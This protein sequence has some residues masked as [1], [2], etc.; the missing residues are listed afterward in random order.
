M[1]RVIKFL[2]AA[3]VALMGT[4]PAR[5]GGYFKT[6]NDLYSSCST[7]KGERFYEFEETLCL[8][9]V[10]AVFDSFSISFGTG[11]MAR[12]FCSPPNSTVVQL[13]DIAVRFLEVNPQWRD[14]PAAT[15]VMA[16]FKEAF[17]CPRMGKAR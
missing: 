5:S 1:S 7:K 10:T 16:S 17:P 9:Y 11:A 3:S 2:I 14:R 4:T 13:R 12:S 8:T 15:L 6:G